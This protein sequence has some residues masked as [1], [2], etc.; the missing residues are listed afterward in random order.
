LEYCRKKD[1]TFLA[2]ALILA[3]GTPHIR[4][5]TLLLARRRRNFHS[6]PVVLAPYRHMG[7]LN[8][9]YSYDIAKMI[10]ANA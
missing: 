4:F 1:L 5:V 7:Y 10:P 2:F 3:R 8:R 6:T 9:R